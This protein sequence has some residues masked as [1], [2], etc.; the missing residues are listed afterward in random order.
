MTTSYASDGQRK[1]G[2]IARMDAVII[3][4]ASAGSG[5]G[6]KT[7]DRCAET[8]RE[9]GMRVEVWNTERPKHATELATR[10]GE[11]LIIVAGGDGTINEVINGMPPE[12]TVTVIPL[13]T[14]NVLAREL[15]MP[16]EPEAACRRILE[17]EVRRMDLGLAT[18]ERGIERRFA[19]MTGIGFDA[20]VVE[21]VTPPIKKRLRGR[22][23]PLMA[24]VVYFTRR[25]SSIHLTAGDREYT[26]RFVIVSNTHYYGGGYRVTGSNSLQGGRL[27]ATVFGRV[28]LLLRPDVL[29]RILLGRPLENYLPSFAAEEIH[30]DQPEGLPV[31]VQ[32][33]G[34]LWGELPVNLRVRPRALKV[35][36]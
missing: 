25:F 26:A 13:G 19:C 5:G 1:R 33:D 24:F 17:G 11:R 12:A 14:A 31:P 36:C 27:H 9:G 15:G 8:L 29:G 35:L 3:G 34:E 2:N 16:L 7:L 30:A 18:N 4:N 10:T 22:A 21:A 20:R 23:F 28:S 32:L 6:E